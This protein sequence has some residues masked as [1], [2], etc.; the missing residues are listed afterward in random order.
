MMPV[1][2]LQ[3]RILTPEEES[4]LMMALTP[5]LRPMVCFALHTG[6]RHTFATR[7]VMHDV[8]T[9][10]LQKW[11]GHCSL[12]MTQRYTHPTLAHEREAIRRLD[13]LP[14]HFTTRPTERVV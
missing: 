14:P 8:D 9:R 4:R 12:V 5:R 3:I 7:V 6:L 11:L 10:T 2:E 1:D 13:H